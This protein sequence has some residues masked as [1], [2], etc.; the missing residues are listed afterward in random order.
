MT[1][2]ENMFYRAKRFNQDIGAW[3]TSSVTS[4][5][6]MFYRASTFNSA[7]GT[8][9][10]GLVTNMKGMFE[11]TNF[12]QNLSNWQ[13]SQMTKKKQCQRFCRYGG[14]FAIDNWPSFLPAVCLQQCRSVFAEP[15]QVF[16]N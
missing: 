16:I 6:R 3:D 10:T 2:M 9:D 8:W 7:I 11:W 4:M 5:Y 13:V 12:N 15:P 1:N 14:T